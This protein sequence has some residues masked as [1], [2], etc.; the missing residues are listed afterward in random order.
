[1][2][3]SVYPY[4]V[5]EAVFMDLSVFSSFT[6]LLKPIVPLSVIKIITDLC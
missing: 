1:M 6:D 3:L 5:V 2:D 4:Q